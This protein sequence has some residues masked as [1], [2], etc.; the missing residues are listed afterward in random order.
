MR[1]LAGLV[2]ILY[3]L[4]VALSRAIGVRPAKIVTFVAVVSVLALTLNMLYKD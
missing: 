4:F 1:L 2:I 3:V